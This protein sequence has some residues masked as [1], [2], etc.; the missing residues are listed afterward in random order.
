MDWLTSLFTG[1]IFGY[2]AGGLGLLFTIWKGGPPLLKKISIF[3][4][5]KY[6]PYQKE[7]NEAITA[8]GKVTAD[9]KLDSAE[10]ELIYEEAKDIFELKKTL[11]KKVLEK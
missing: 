5:T 4:V 9:G 2:I 7:I 10:I 8:I 11:N 3:I 1:N 6:A